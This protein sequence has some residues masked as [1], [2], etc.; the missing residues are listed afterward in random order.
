MGYKLIP[1]LRESHL[2]APSAHGG[3]KFTQPRAHLLADPCR[4]EPSHLVL[5][6]LPEVKWG[7]VSAR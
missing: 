2:L 5:K 4:L 3:G 1:R 7:M 6:V